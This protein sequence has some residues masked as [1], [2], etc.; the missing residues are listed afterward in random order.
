MLELSPLWN[1]TPPLLRP[2]FLKDLYVVGVHECRVPPMPSFVTPESPCTEAGRLN[3]LINL[4]LGRVVLARVTQYVSDLD[5]LSLP[6]TW[7]TPTFRG[8]WGSCSGIL[9]VFPRLFMLGQDSALESGSRF[10]LGLGSGSG[11]NWGLGLGP[12][13]V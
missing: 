11:F 4:S 10:S 12:D 6:H 3:D 5:Y 8:T 9:R 1:R 13:S 2:L 7:V